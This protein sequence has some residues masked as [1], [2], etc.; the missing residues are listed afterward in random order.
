MFVRCKGTAAT[1][2]YQRK[3]RTRGGGGVEVWTN[4][5]SP[6]RTLMCTR[7]IRTRDRYAGRIYFAITFDRSLFVAYVSFYWFSQSI[8]KG[9]EG[10]GPSPASCV[11]RLIKCVKSPAAGMGRCRF[12]CVRIRNQA[13][14]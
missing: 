1:G 6:T 8:T 13:L 2:R 11:A 3:I 12:V 9:W 14:I 10:E 5:F 7:C 4:L